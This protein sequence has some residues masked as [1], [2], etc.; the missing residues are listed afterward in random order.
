MVNGSTT[1]VALWEGGC[2]GPRADLNRGP[3]PAQ[4]TLTG[5]SGEG[6]VALRPDVVKCALVCICTPL[7][8]EANEHVVRP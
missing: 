5:R 4:H 8:L 1:A 6:L 7:E 2:V 3:L